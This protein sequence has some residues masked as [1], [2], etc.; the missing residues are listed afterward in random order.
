MGSHRTSRKELRDVEIQLSDPAVQ[1]DQQ[2]LADSGRRYKQ[3]EEV[4]GVGRRLR[5][6]TEDLA[7]AQ[8]MARRRGRRPC[9]DARRDRVARGP[10]PLPRG[11][12]TGP[13]VARRSQRRPQRHRGDPGRRRG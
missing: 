5:S 13:A 11:R 1:A 9:R 3:L 7:V 6:A 4:V 10:D 8:E 2:Q 12:A